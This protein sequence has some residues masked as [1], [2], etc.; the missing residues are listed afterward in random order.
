MNA[1]YNTQY[2]CIWLS[3]Q[4]SPMFLE[5]VQ[6]TY[7]QYF[8]FQ[9]LHDVADAYFYLTIQTQDSFFMAN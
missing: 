7:V 5:S 6:N 8:F 9:H 1:C 3:T 2:H 4:I